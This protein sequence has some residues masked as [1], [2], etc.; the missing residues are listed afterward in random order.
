MVT[1]YTFP[2]SKW[3]FPLLKI[4]RIGLLFIFLFLFND[5]TQESPS[6]HIVSFLKYSLAVYQCE[7]TL[8][9][10]FTLWINSRRILIQGFFI[11]FRKVITFY[12]SWYIV[13]ACLNFAIYICL[14]FLTLVKVWICVLLN[15]GIRYWLFLELLRLNSV[16]RRLWSHFFVIFNVLG[17][18]VSRSLFGYRSLNNCLEIIFNLRRISFNRSNSKSVNASNSYLL[19]ILYTMMAMAEMTVKITKQMRS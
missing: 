7:G 2:I 18:D 8:D 10:F 9:W 17:F 14:N 13:I 4:W 3:V 15:H 19:I 1:L 5:L 16:N 12:W 11:A 6:S